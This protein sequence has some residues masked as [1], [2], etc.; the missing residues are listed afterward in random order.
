[1]TQ[2]V[3]VKRRL[4]VADAPFSMKDKLKGAG[5]HWDAERKQWWIGATAEAEAEAAIRRAKAL[6]R[7]SVRKPDGVWEG[8]V[9]RPDNFKQES[10]D[11]RRNLH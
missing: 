1:M 7:E 4:Y 2:I 5:C 9:F 3:K 11:D 10:D 8:N 6:S